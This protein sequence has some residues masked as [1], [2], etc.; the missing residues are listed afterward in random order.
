[1]PRAA[2]AFSGSRGHGFRQPAGIGR[3]G[4]QR[5]CSRV[6]DCAASASQQDCHDAM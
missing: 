5:G 1:M 4:A 2:D 6:S 3:W